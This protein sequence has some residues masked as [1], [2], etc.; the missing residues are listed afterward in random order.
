MLNR[1]R[2]SGRCCAC[3]AGNDIQTSNTSL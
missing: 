1:Y 3:S 2:N